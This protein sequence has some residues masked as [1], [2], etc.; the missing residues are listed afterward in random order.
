MSIQDIVFVTGNANK[1]KEVKMILSSESSKFNLI[2]EPLDLE[3]IQDVDLKSIAMAKCKQ[4]SEILGPNRPVF[5]ED[6]AL[7]FDEF[8][9]LPGAY[10]KWFVKSMGLAKIVQ[11]LD[12]FDN[13]DAKAITTIVYADGK[14]EFHVF[15]GITEGTIVS[16]RGPTTFGW[17]SIFQPKESTNGQ[18]YAEMAKEDKNL[19]SQR[20]RAFAQLKTFLAAE[21]M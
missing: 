21:S 12:S 13:K 1:L 18:T 11:M 9:G 3:E 5:V 8:N 6:T 17:D 19:I 14:G 15:Q 7:V 16:S 10:I 4:A 2:N 20:G